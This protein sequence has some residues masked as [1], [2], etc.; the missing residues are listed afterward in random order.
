MGFSPWPWD[1]T[2]AAVDWTWQQLLLDG[3]L[4]SQHLEEGVPWK[5]AES[6]APFP[7]DYQSSLNDGKARAGAKAM[8]LSV[9]PLDVGRKHLAPYRGAQPNTPLSAPWDGYA[10]D[11]IHVK[12]AYLAYVKR[13]ADFFSPAFLQTGIEVNLLRSNTDVAT[14]AQLVALQCHVYQA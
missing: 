2:Q 7:P 1:A 14:W 9:N 13:M 8:L 11:D 6:G 5:E 4:V 12:N 10:L 3:D